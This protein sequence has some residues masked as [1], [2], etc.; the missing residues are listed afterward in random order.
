MTSSGSHYKPIPE[1]KPLLNIRV[2]LV[3]YAFSVSVVLQTLS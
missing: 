3:R 2:A 1:V